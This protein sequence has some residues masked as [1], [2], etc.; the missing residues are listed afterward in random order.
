MQSYCCLVFTV[1]VL[2]PFSI[3]FIPNYVVRGAKMRSRLA[4]NKLECAHG[5]CNDVAV[6]TYSKNPIIAVSIRSCQSLY[7][8]AAKNYS[9]LLIFTEKFEPLM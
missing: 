3:S 1:R 4:T 7:V 5:I 9:A 6:P 8:C 2:E